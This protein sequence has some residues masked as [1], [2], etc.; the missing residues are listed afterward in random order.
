MLC[1]AS[2]WVQASEGAGCVALMMLSPP[3]PSE[4][5]EEAQDVPFDSAAG[6]AIGQFCMLA[7]NSVV[8]VIGLSLALGCELLS[9]ASASF[10]TRELIVF[11]SPNSSDEAWLEDCMVAECLDLLLERAD[12]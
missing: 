6:R 9:L 7:R 2:Q 4:L 11:A 5:T 3:Q 1:C 8:N 10:V 12:I